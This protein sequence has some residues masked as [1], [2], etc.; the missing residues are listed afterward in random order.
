MGLRRN[1]WP[2]AGRRQMAVPK[3]LCILTH[4]CIHTCTTP[5]KSCYMRF[6]RDR[7]NTTLTPSPIGRSCQINCAEHHGPGARC[8]A[9]VSWPSEHRPLDPDG[10][11]TTGEGAVCPLQQGHVSWQA[12]TN[13][14]KSTHKQHNAPTRATRQ[15]AQAKAA[16][17][18]RSRKAHARNRQAND[19]AR[20]QPVR[21]SH[22]TQAANT[23]MRGRRISLTA[24][25]QGA[26]LTPPRR[27][28]NNNEQAQPAGKKATSTMPRQ[29]PHNAHPGK[30]NQIETKEHK[31][32]GDPDERRQE[33]AQASRTPNMQKPRSTQT[34]LAM[35][36]TGGAALTA[37]TGN[38]EAPEK[39][40]RMTTCP[41]IR[42]TSGSQPEVEPCAH[43]QAMP[44]VPP[45][46]NAQS[47]IRAGRRPP[48]APEMAT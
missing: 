44:R 5:T 9:C 46:R 12:P 38:D 2:N 18:R 24:M 31:A 41:G 8:G 39:M 27:R 3:W 15:G 37:Q 19:I 35:S 10:R 17:S 7:P 28:R 20:A 1:R 11:T 34:H 13:A 23:R 29:A 22:R 42:A 16:T 40:G 30:C 47:E 33:A 32:E 6:G 45:R 14:T 43:D 26:S 25:T 21:G 36:S 48:E 4:A